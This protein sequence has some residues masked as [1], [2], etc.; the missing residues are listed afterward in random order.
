MKREV[1]N[2]TVLQKKGRG[3]AEGERVGKREGVLRWAMLTVVECSE[4]D[5]KR[6][7]PLD[8]IHR[9]TLRHRPTISFSWHIQRAPRS[10]SNATNSGMASATQ[11]SSAIPSQ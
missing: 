9:K 3:E 11:M 5:H 7:R 4:A 10:L 8:P 2:T 1:T 6:Y